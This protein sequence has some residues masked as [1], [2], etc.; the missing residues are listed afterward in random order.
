M[1]MFSGREWVVMHF[2]NN[3]TGDM[4][5]TAKAPGCHDHCGGIIGSMLDPK[6]YYTVETAMYDSC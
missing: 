6:Q 4:D 5:V 1:D 3:E 2:K